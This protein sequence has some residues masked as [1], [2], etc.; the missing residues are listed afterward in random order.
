MTAIR[1]FDILCVHL[2]HKTNLQ[3]LESNCGVA[4]YY[5]FTRMLFSRALLAERHDRAR[6]QGTGGRHGAALPHS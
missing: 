6:A 1:R 4:P 5:A 2:L 3:T